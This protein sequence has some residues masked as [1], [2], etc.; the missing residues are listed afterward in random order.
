MSLAEISPGVMNRP[1]NQATREN[2]NKPLLIRLD[3]IRVQKRAPL[4]ISLEEVWRAFLRLIVFR[5]GGQSEAQT[6][7][8]PRSGLH[9]ARG[10]QSRKPRSSGTLPA[11]GTSAP[12]TGG[13]ATLNPRLLPTL[14]VAGHAAKGRLARGGLVVMNINPVTYSAALF[15]AGGVARTLQITADMLGARALPARK[16][17]RRLRHRIYAHHH[18]A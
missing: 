15:R 4:G 8:K 5:T 6:P 17:P 2:V 11:C 1:R 3:L 14:R 16:I 7:G 18:L 13:I 10:C 9:P 12:W